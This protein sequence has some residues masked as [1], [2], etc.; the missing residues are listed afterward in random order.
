VS[1]AGSDA[2]GTAPDAARRRRRSALACLS[3]VLGLRRV[4]VGAEGEGFEP[5][6]SPARLYG[7]GNGLRGFG[8]D[9]KPS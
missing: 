6:A 7:L 2:P 4:I 1:E 3:G 9:G 8:A 5:Y